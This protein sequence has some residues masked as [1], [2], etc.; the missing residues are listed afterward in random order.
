MAIK[1][2][3]PAAI[4]SVD[5]AKAFLTEL[6]KNDECFHPEDD[7]NDLSGDPFTKEEGDLL[8]KLMSDIYELNGDKPCQDWVFDPCLFILELDPDYKLDDN[9]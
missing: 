3:L 5:E 8:N 6:Y 9:E 2:V 7:A 4:T 1:T